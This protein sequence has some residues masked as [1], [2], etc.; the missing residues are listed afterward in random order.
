MEEYLDEDDDRL[1]ATNETLR[2][3]LANTDDPGYNLLQTL[4]GLFD[5]YQ[6]GVQKRVTYTPR[7]KIEA[8]AGQSDCQYAYRALAASSGNPGSN[9]S[10][11]RDTRYIR[12]PGSTTMTYRKLESE[13]GIIISVHLC[14]LRFF[15]KICPR[16]Y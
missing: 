14:S 9:F 15:N 1:A 16:L 13:V 10:K 3:G 11:H 12:A 7:C 4:V 8:R 5:T 6:S 2:S